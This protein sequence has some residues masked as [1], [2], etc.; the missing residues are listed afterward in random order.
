MHACMNI[1]TI[2][3]PIEGSYADCFYGA[4]SGVERSGVP[5]SGFRIVETKSLQAF[6]AFLY[7][8][9]SAEHMV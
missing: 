7:I 4:E 5:D 9:A 6:H 3:R 1:T 2:W 8:F